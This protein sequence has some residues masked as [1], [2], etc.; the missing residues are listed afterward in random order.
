VLFGLAK[1][2][3]TEDDAELRKQL[4]TV[5]AG[6]EGVIAFDNVPKGMVVRSGVL[7]KLLTDR[8]WA[9]RLL[10]GNVLAKF[11]NDRLWCATGN[12]LR[13]GGDMRSRSVLIAL[14]PKMPHP[15]RRGGFAIGNLETWIEAPGNQREVM[16][17]LLVL[18]ADWAAAGCPEADVML[19]RQF[20]PWARTAAGF[21]AHHGVEGFL[22]NAAE[23]EQA[24]DD[25]H[26]W[27]QFL[28]RWHAILGGTAVTSEQL[29][30]MADDGRWG[31]TF[32]AGKGGAALSAM[33]LGRRLGGECGSYHGWYVLRS[34]T[35]HE[36]SRWWWVDTLPGAPSPYV[37]QSAT[38]RN[39]LPWIDANGQVRYPAGPSRS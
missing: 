9:D 12:N 35:E 20:T 28:A 23:L 4:T 34:R 36:S 31:G 14:D 2:I 38:Q 19:M 24:D 25:D 37:P 1:M 3:W 13:L 16:T 8:T 21:L 17:A 39:D 27:A 6:Q 18:V 10:G 7:A 33:G 11:A 22:A 5:M 15:E 29:R 32:P 26:D 30:Q